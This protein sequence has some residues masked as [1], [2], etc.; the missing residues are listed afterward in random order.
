MR[1]AKVSRPLLHASNAASLGFFQ[2]AKSRFDHQAMMAAGVADAFFPE[3]TGGAALIGMTGSKIPVAIAIG[4]NQASFI[5]AVNRSEESLLVNIGTSGQISVFTHHNTHSP[6]VDIRPLTQDGFLLVGSSLCGGR[7]YALLEKFFRSVVQIATG[8]EPGELYEMMNQLASDFP[9]GADRLEI[10]TTF[11]GTRDHPDQKA[12]IRNLGVDNFTPRHF[13]AGVLEGVVR[14]LHDLYEGMVPELS[15]KPKTLI[16]SGNAMRLCQ[17]LQKAASDMF[18]M[19]INI[20]R[21]KEEAAYGTALFALVATG[22]FKT[23][24]E[25]QSLVR[26]VSSGNNEIGC[27]AI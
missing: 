25:A 6:Q 20:P 2:L 17:P 5:G 11:S 15:Q 22:H 19:P 8:S 10:S 9:P 26:Y 21:Y 27:Y 14:E 18:G 3:A 7:S 12:M 24:A 16:G 13:I 4:D 23:L 1:L